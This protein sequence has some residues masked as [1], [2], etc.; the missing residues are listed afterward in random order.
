MAIPIKLAGITLDIP[1]EDLGSWSTDRHEEDLH[2]F[3]SEYLEQQRKKPQKYYRPDEPRINI[4]SV[5]GSEDRIETRNITTQSSIPERA[6]CHLAVTLD[7]GNLTACTGFFVAPRKVVTAGHCLYDKENEV[8]AN[9]IIVRPG[10]HRN[11][12]D[13]IVAP[14]QG[15][16]AGDLRVPQQWTDGLGPNQPNFNFDWGLIS[17][18]SEDLYNRAGRPEFQLWAPSDDEIGQNLFACWGY[19]NL[20]PFPNERQFF[21][22]FESMSPLR[23][24][25]IYGIQD[26]TP[27]N[28]GGPLVLNWDTKTPGI[29]SHQYE[30]CTHPNGFTR[31]TADVKRTI[32]EYM[33]P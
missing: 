1:K 19:P 33:W 13:Q 20:A 28:S 29:V 15:E 21:S 23:Q 16:W 2:R 8:W 27:G 11:Q 7:N 26:T 18:A 4:T 6:T 12:Q 14:F 25:I 30:N 31:I 32:D 9:R 17:L 24:Y 5:C 10:L 3:I 22:P